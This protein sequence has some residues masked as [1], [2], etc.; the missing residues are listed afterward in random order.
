M[1]AGCDIRQE[2]IVLLPDKVK[3]PSWGYVLSER[4]KGRLAFLPL[5]YKSHNFY[6]GIVP[7]CR[8]CSI[9]NLGYA[10]LSLEAF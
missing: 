8:I 5:V 4:I 3:L 1:N 7:K 10:L 6:E 2:T 9:R